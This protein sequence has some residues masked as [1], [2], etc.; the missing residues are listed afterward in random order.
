MEDQSKPVQEQDGSRLALSQCSNSHFMTWNKICAFLTYPE[1]GLESNFIEHVTDHP[2]YTLYYP[3]E[4]HRLWRIWAVSI[5]PTA[6]HWQSSEPW[7]SSGSWEPDVP[8][9]LC[10]SHSHYCSLTVTGTEVEG[11]KQHALMCPAFL[12]ARIFKL[13]WTKVTSEVV[14]G[15]VVTWQ[16]TVWWVRFPFILQNTVVSFTPGLSLYHST[17]GTTATHTFETQY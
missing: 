4:T 1:S 17:T 6:C 10:R 3:G 14:P 7:Q 13:K 11:W 16:R 2:S 12:S 15:S 5:L 8:V 9:W